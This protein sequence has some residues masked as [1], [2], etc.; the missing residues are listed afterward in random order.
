MYINFNV[1]DRQFQMYR[2]EYTEAAIKT[3]ESGCYVLGRELINFEN[4]F[5]SFLGRKYCVGLNSGLDSLTL[6]F[7][8][9]DIGEGDEV[10]VPANT[11]IASVLAITRNGAIPVF[12]EPDQY[13]NIDAENI[14]RYITK[15]TK[16]ILAVHLY[17][18]SCYMDPIIEVVDRNHLL[19]VE[20][21]AQS[22][23]AGYKGKMTGSFGHI[24]CFS[25]YP[26][27]N[28]GAFGDGGAIVT[29]N[30]ELDEKIRMLRNYGSRIKN[31]HEIEGY[32]SRLDEIQAALLNVKLSHIYELNLERK[33]I[34]NRYLTEIRNQQIIL[35]EKRED[36]DHIY[37]IF[38]IKTKN[39]SGFR[40]YMDKNGVST[41]VHYPIPPHLSQCYRYMGIK[42]GSFP[43]TERFAEEIVSIPLYNGMLDSEINYVID[44]I[45]GYQ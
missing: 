27:K 28:L 44:I 20:D 18:Q 14:D 5:G 3:L 19:L 30:E 11:Y 40:E 10:I 34:A 16:A 12:A 31:Q 17:G 1:L 7:K 45:N 4:N 21:C 33:N 13:F 2:N 38:V 24:S 22:H 37:H 36:T 9:L 43:I 39:R 23:G 35:P 42:K 41:Q 15:K 32:N 8:A 6:A 26:T 29:D 25:F